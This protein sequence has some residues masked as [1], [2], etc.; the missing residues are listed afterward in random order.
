[1]SDFRQFNQE[2]YSD[3]TRT[4][5]LKLKRKRRGRFFVTAV[6]L[7]SFLGALGYGAFIYADEVWTMVANRYF[8][9]RINMVRAAEPDAEPVQEYRHLNILLVGVD[10]REDEPARSDTLMVAMLNLPDKKVNVIS[11]PRDTRVKIE[12]LKNKTR[13]NHAQPNGGV[14]LTRKTVEELLGIPVHNYIETNFRGFE[15]IIDILGGVTLDVEKRMYYP[16]EDIDLQ[17]GRQLLNGH[18]ALGYVR[19]RSDGKGDLPRIDRQH[20]FLSTLADQVLQPKTL[21]KL[22]KLVGELYDNV[23]TDLTLRD[24]LVL[25]GEFK[26]INPDSIVFSNVPGTPRYINGA[27]YYEVDEEELHI[28]M[29][30]ILNGEALQAAPVEDEQGLSPEGE[31]V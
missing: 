14:E 2:Y 12:G 5:R 15:N 24:L 30:R 8:K 11:I 25:T 13:I 1:M 18:D 19:F 9:D 23:E 7:L 16:D 29:E 6:F 26:N 21:L 27:A 20:R 10:Q 31:H 22:P 28:L 17:K 3:C 4:Q